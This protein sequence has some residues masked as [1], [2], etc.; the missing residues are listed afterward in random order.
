[1]REEER[2]EVTL[3]IRVSLWL[4]NN[5][6]PIKVTASLLSDSHENQTREELTQSQRCCYMLP[7][8][9]ELYIRA[10]TAC[11]LSL[12]TENTDELPSKSNQN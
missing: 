11:I 5:A 8:N 1:M 12:P 7:L 6:A 3:F 9:T 4:L 2:R 10:V